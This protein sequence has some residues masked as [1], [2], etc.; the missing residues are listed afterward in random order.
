MEWYSVRML[1]LP[2]YIIPLSPGASHF[3]SRARIRS[4]TTKEGNVEM[5]PPQALSKG[6]DIFSY[7]E[8]PDCVD[9]SNGSFDAKGSYTFG[10][11]AAGRSAATAVA[12]AWRALA[13]VVSVIVGV[14]RT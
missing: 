4:D 1:E 8:D 9:R 12:S 11:D 5:S 3:P 2:K 6:A 7:A 10:A 14:R 13:M